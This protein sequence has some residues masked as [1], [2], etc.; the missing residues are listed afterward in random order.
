VHI[1]KVKPFLADEMPRSWITTAEQDEQ[2]SQLPPEERVQSVEDDV[3]TTGQGLSEE[4]RGGVDTAI[5]G[6]PP[7][8][9][10][11]PRPQRRAGRPRRYLD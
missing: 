2:V 4:Q 3:D 11:S 9:C 1:D 6:V 5:A 8:A 10:R 7:E